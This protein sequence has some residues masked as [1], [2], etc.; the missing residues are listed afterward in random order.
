MA[1]RLD[2]QLELKEASGLQFTLFYRGELKANARPAA[3]HAIRQRFHEQFKD[4][5]QHAPLSNFQRLLEPE[6]GDLSLIQAIHG[7]NF[8]PLVAES[9]AL[10]AELRILLLWPG[11]P[12][13]I[14]TSGGDID[15]RL[16]TL[17]DAL[18]VPSEPTALPNGTRPG[19]GE[20]PFYCLLEDDSLVTHLSVGTERLLEPVATSSEV[21]A[22]IRVE[23][24]QL[25]VFIG[26]I[27]LA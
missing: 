15:N 18:K 5:W 8:A 27:G 14:I 26:T 10:V 20:D 19:I 6:V 3:K 11:A 21:V 16:K 13:R 2:G 23:T 17:L 9:V 25:E 24:K 12:G 4:L 7:F 22:V 1:C